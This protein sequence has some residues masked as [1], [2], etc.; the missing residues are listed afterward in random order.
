MCACVC[1]LVVWCG[2]VEHEAS[3]VSSCAAC[4][5]TAKNSGAFCRVRPADSCPALPGGMRSCLPAACTEGY[6]VARMAESSWSSCIFL[7]HEALLVRNDK[8]GE[9]RGVSRPLF[10][11]THSHT[12]AGSRSQASK[13]ARLP[14]WS[15]QGYSTHMV[16]PRFGRL[17]RRGC[18]VLYA[19]LGRCYL[20]CF[21]CV[22]WTGDSQF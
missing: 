4:N 18:G 5:L 9:E 15:V 1:A 19:P 20:S 12:Q 16:V 6:E 10:T 8:F 22:S 2:D 3:S 13:H 14:R 21:S 7:H 17:S 11:Y